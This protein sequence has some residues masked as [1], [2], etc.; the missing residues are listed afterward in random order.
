MSQQE[1][2]N[3]CNLLNI[4]TIEIS[5]LGYLNRKPLVFENEPA[6]HKLLDIIGDLSLIG[7][8]IKGKVIAHKPGHTFNTQVAKL[9]LNYINQTK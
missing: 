8:P 1:V 4:P 7:L 5:E 3:L 2:D 6:R 9:I